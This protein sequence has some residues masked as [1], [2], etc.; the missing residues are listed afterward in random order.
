[1]KQLLARC[2]LGLA[3]AAGAALVPAAAA[4]GPRTPPAP[5]GHDWTRFGWDAGRSNASTAPTGIDAANVAALRRQQ[6]R[7]DGTVDASPIYLSGV[8]V[9][10]RPRD[11]FFVTTTYGK[12]IAV[13]AN[14]G[15]MLWEYTPAGYGSWAGTYRITTATPVADPD[16]RFVYA[17]SPDGH[18]QK[19]AVADGH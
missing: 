4:R 18:I 6:V 5:S 19:L 9:H 1:M 15:S 8:A 13:D 10:G 7:L 14:D 12:T 16:R 3:L 2:G 17:A 11:V